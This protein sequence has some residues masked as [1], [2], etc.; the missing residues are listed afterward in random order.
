MSI[1]NCFVIIVLFL[2]VRLAQPIAALLNVDQLSASAWLLSAIALAMVI[3]MGP[4]L[5]RH[6]KRVVN[7]PG[8]ALL[9]YLVGT[10]IFFT[11]LFTSAY[12][13]L[14]SPFNIVADLAKMG[15]SEKLMG[16]LC[17]AVLLPFIETAVYKALTDRMPIAY[18]EI[19]TMIL[20]GLMFSLVNCLALMP[21]DISLFPLYFLLNALYGFAIAYLY[22][23]TTS[24]MVPE[25]A[26]SLAIIIFHIGTLWL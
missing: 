14:S 8:I 5:Q 19:P 22:N 12:I 26:L 25:M 10:A 1:P 13:D 2:L 7:Q 6:I 20:S 21:L 24:L 3:L 15:L 9:F 11:L 4:V 16:L 18:N 17:V 23:Q